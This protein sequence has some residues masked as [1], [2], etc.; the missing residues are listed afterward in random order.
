MKK[1]IKIDRVVRSKRKRIGLYVHP[2]S[3]VTV[4]AP[5]RTPLFLIKQVVANRANWILDK[6]TK[7][8]KKYGSI[9]KREYRVG[10]L[11]WYLGK[12][13]PLA[14]VQQKEKIIWDGKRF[15]L[16]MGTEG[17][18]AFIQWYR[19]TARIVITERVNMYSREQN[20]PY[21]NMRITSAKT[22]WGS[23]SG[24]N[25]LN[26]TWRLI[27]APLDVIDYVVVHELVH[28]KEKNH[29]P[30]FWKSLKAIIPDAKKKQHFL[31]NHGPHF[32]L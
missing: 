18:K 2:D 32:L 28:T 20:L 1:H 27:M 29:G 3:T 16:Q 24:E 30:A 19:D 4:R 9:K 14:I 25:N 12:K 8:K 11:F 31:K 26:F 6:Q 15:S 22:R 21:H 13:Y 5:L 17:E 10:E 7:A 23:C